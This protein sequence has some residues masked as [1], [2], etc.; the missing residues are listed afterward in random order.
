MI[1][2][3][4]ELQAF[5]PFPTA[6][7]IDFK[8]FEDE[9]I[10]LITGQTG[11]G[12][13]T[14]F[15]AIT[16]A[17]FGQPSGSIRSCD[18]FKSHFCDDTVPCFVRFVFS[19][20]D[21]VFTIYREPSQQKRKLNNSV[22][23]SSPV[24][25]ITLFDGTI[26][27]GISAVNSKIAQILGVN[28]EQFIK[29][30]MLP[31]GEF[32]RF[33]SE[34][35][36][37]KQETLRQIF[38]TYTLEKF[39]NRLSDDTAKLKQSLNEINTV[40]RGNIDAICADDN[41][42]LLDSKEKG[43]IDIIIPLL[44]EYNAYL[45]DEKS[46]A[47][48]NIIN[49]ENE[50]NG[51]NLSY[52]IENNRRIQQ[53]EFEKQN[54]VDLSNDL[55]IFTKKNKRLELLRAVKSLSKDDA[56]L[57]TT[58][59]FLGEISVKLNSL[60]AKFQVISDELQH[61]T[62]MVEGALAATKTIPEKIKLIEQ[63]KIQQGLFNELC[64]IDSK[65]L[66]TV[67]EQKKEAILINENKKNALVLKLNLQQLSSEK[68]ALEAYNA[69]LVEYNEAARNYQICFNNFLSCQ[70]AI[71]SETL[72]DNAP[73]PVCGSPDHPCPAAI[74]NDIVT[75]SNLDSVKMRYDEITIKVEQLKA[76]CGTD[77][78][79]VLDQKLFQIMHEVNSCECAVDGLTI[80]S[81]DFD[82]RVLEDEI[83]AI[84][85]NIAS[86]HDEAEKLRQKISFEYT[87][88]E[89][90]LQNI[91]DLKNYVNSV[92]AEYDVIN[93]KYM[94]CR[95][96][97]E[98]LSES[99]AQTNEQIAHNKK[100][101][102]DSKTTLISMLNELDLTYYDFRIYLDQ[103]T[104]INKLENEI[105]HYNIL[106]A[107]KK[108]LIIS[109][110][111][112][113]RGIEC[114]NLTTLQQRSDELDEGLALQKFSLEI[115][116]RV[117]NIN[118]MVFDKLAQNR[119]SLGRVLSRYESISSIYNVAIG[120]KSNRIGFESYVLAHYFNQV[121]KNANLRLN[122]MTDKR[123]TLIIRQEKEKFGAYSGLELNV[124]DSY[125]GRQRDV[126]TLSGGESF[127]ISLA[128]SLGLADI[129][130]E[131]SGGIDIKTLFIDEGFGSLDANS[132]DAAIE[133][134]YSL[135]LQGRYIGIISHV[136][137]LKERINAK[138]SVVQLPTGSYIE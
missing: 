132:L 131:I 40:I 11:S 80:D 49:F 35:T 110:T 99:I 18:F 12:K 135:R 48:S 112:Y 6:Q 17:L 16:F 130:T 98:R 30:A 85:Q 79:F 36:A 86:K 101:Y 95:A 133:C 74:S 126:D 82:I 8:Q 7:K 9:G 97:Y 59:E 45:A 137:E 41:P 27:S 54:L 52:H 10:F 94:I 108:E 111:D 69:A 121:V 31:Q 107:S 21:E 122:Q 62:P 118:S 55:P 23:K 87:S 78:L 47:E 1:P 125:T 92:N 51:L 117:L 43:D 81:I 64:Q 26:L 93:K 3:M 57:T 13:T 65:L 105:N 123:F 39:I 72:V 60:T 103:V 46:S 66:A 2:L 42:Q 90:F 104:D 38:K 120:N 63:L 106:V 20:K 129:T 68:A 71:L 136:A 127:K 138:I 89:Q 128:L 37:A 114:V 88:N 15:D 44:V 109:L 76:K 28:Y 102:N 115:I 29:I 56:T 124:L 50:K 24:A 34:K 116:S 75:Q 33:L 73:C 77:E 19:I 83:I 58:K 67:I 70:A 4:L 22:V 100:I 61:L 25:Q 113:L 119:D 91:F 14:I 32:R 84:E 96:N 53:L 134:L 5:G